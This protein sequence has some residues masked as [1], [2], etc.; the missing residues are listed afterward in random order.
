MNLGFI[1]LGIMGKPMAGHLL[2]GGHTLFAMSRSGV[3][4]ELIRK[5][6]VGVR[7]IRP[8][9]RSKADIIILMVTDTPMSRRCCSDR[10]ASLRA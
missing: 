8:R 6:A 7:H 3:P 5:G 10:R 4:E 9:S 1:G 2:A